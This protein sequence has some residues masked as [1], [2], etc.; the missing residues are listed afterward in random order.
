MRYTNRI[1]PIS[2]LKANA[3]EILTN[4][5]EQR[6]HVAGEDADRDPELLL[7]EREREVLAD[8]DPEER[9]G[10]REGSGSTSVTRVPGICCSSRAWSARRESASRRAPACSLA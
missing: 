5:A 8:Q 7:V 10:D 9:R 2:Y 3:A 1:K 4:L 6:E